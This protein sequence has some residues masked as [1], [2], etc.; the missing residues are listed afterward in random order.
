MKLR[1]LQE[2]VY[3]GDAKVIPRLAKGEHVPRQEYQ[4][5]TV[6]PG[7]VLDGDKLDPRIVK[8]LLDNGIA[9]EVSDGPLR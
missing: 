7:Q 1:V 6:T 3:P 2:G 5:V 8:S 4:P 9:E